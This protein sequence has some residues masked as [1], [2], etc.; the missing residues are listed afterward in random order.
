MGYT[1]VDHGPHCAAFGAHAKLSKAPTRIIAAVIALRCAPCSQNTSK[2]PS[3]FN[4]LTNA[5]NKG[6]S[7]D[8]K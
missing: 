3:V 6:S 8:F 5:T 7:C 1:H 4:H 2:L